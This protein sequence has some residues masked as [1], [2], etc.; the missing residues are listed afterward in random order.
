MYKFNIMKREFIVLILRYTSMIYSKCKYCI[1]LN[2]NKFFMDDFPLE[3]Y[4]KKF[5]RRFINIW[6]FKNTLIDSTLNISGERNT[7]QIFY[8]SLFKHRNYK[9]SKYIMCPKIY[10]NNTTLTKNDHRVYYMSGLYQ[11]IDRIFY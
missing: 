10:F 3:I 9:V 2:Y 5:S 8:I 6:F 7:S 11:N 1:S 4:M